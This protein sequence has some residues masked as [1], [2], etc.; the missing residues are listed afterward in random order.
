SR[1]LSFNPSE[2]ERRGFGDRVQALEDERVLYQIKTLNADI[3]ATTAD[4]AALRFSNLEVGKT[5]RLSGSAYIEAN[6]SE[7]EGRLEAYH[8]GV[9]ILGWEFDQE[10]SSG[11]GQATWGN[12]IVFV[13]TTS[14]I[15]FN[16]EEV[17]TAT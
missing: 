2:V 17:N 9:N 11:T 3:T 10:A 12:A 6:G 5:Y 14:S 13:A 1:Y 8:N 16:F 4:I 7:S 15:T